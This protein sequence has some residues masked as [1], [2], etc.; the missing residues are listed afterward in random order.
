MKALIFSVLMMSSMG[1]AQAIDL[2]TLK[3]LMTERQAQVES[4]TVGMTKKETTLGTFQT[5]LNE[6][7][8]Y[9]QIAIETVLKVELERI[10][11]YSH[12]IF[13]PANTPG[14]HR[15]AVRPEVQKKIYYQA[16]P[17]LADDLAALD[18]NAADI[19]SIDR[20][21]E[22]VTI[23]LNLKAEQ[24]DGTV[25]TDLIT[26]AYDLS[27][28]SFKNLI[29]NQ[30]KDYTISTTNEADIVPSSVDLSDILF[31]ENNDGDETECVP[32]DYSDILN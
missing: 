2:P 4:V 5:R 29:L 31:C 12:E 10:L 27:L 11:I 23:K 32:G 26:V 13:S 25:D 30:G 1:F 24:E 16:R 9:K 3:A 7:C 17:K 22:V 6:S 14:C 28:P 20:T 19:Q 15:G 18:A 8:R 21:G